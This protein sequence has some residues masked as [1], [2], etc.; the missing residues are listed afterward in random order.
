MDKCSSHLAVDVEERLSHLKVKHPAGLLCQP[1]VKVETDNFNSLSIGV[2]VVLL[3][4]LLLQRQPDFLQSLATTS[5]TG[6]TA[7][8]SKLQ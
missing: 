5:N 1:Q 8:G 3:L 4:V 7:F 2:Q 6:H